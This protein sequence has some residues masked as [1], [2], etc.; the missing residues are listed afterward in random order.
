[1]RRTIIALAIFLSACA[2]TAPRIGVQ[3][4]ADRLYCGRDIPGTNLTVSDAEI[5]AFVREVVLPR[6]PEG[7]TMWDAQGTWEG[8]EEQTLVLEFLHPYGRE[9]DREVREI[10]DEYRRRFKQ[11]SVM[12]VTTPALMEFV[13]K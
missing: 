5:D 3:G 13:D 8:D 2:T 4:T 10:A 11:K 7:F 12:R 6:F 9:Y 1:M